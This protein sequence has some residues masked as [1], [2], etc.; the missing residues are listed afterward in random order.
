MGKNLTKEQQVMLVIVVCIIG[1][2]YFYWA[3]LLKPTRETINTREQKLA[4]L[5]KKIE[6]AEMQSRR[7]PALRNELEKLQTELSSL[8]KQLP[9]DKDLPNIIRTLTTEAIR[10]NLEFSNVNPGKPA[11][12]QYFE[13]IPF[14][15]SFEGS[16][17]GLARFL[18][19]LGQQERIFK[20]SNITLSPKGGGIAID[21]GQLL[22]IKLNIETYAYKG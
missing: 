10:E 4:G 14:N 7:L 12:Q 17:H 11:G 3:K 1:G 8:E 6:Q 16:I 20:A 18:A 9:R 19:S 22:S 13:I 15:I 2:I 21:G 5:V